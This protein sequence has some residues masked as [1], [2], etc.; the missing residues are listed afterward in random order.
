MGPVQLGPE[1]ARG[2][3]AAVKDENPDA[4]LMGEHFFDATDDAQRRRVGRGHELRRVHR[5]RSLGWLH[6]GVSSA[7][8]SGVG[9]SRRARTSTADELVAALEAFRAAVPWAVARCQYDLLGSHDTAADPASVGGDAGRA[10]GG[11]RAAARRTSACRGCCTATR[12]ASRARTGSASRLAMPWDQRG[13]GPRAAGVRPR[14]WSGSACASRALQAGG[15]QV[16]EAGADRLRLPARHGRRA[17]DRRRRPRA[18]VRGPPSRSGRPTGRSP[19][20]RC[21]RPC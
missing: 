10:A 19:T 6:G 20:A 21:S 15:F 8:A 3:R 14:P 17:G 11:V 4:Y 13:L 18:G 12:S 5:A 16:L 2:I 9:L 1:V 7:T